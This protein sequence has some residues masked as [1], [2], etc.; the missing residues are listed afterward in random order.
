MSFAD[1]PTARA[2]YRAHNGS[3]VAAYL[4]HRDLAE[5]ENEAERF[6][7]NVVLCRVLYTHALG[8]L[9]EGRGTRRCRRRLNFTPP[10]TPGTRR[11]WLAGVPLRPELPKG[12]SYA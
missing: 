10:S 6:F 7:M 9:T 4:Q 11:G 12:Q 5:A 2:W 3:V 8:Q 1:Y